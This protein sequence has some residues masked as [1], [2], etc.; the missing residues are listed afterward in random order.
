MH[1]FDMQLLVT[2]CLSKLAKTCCYFNCRSTTNEGGTCM[3]IHKRITAS[4]I[5]L[6]AVTLLA[7]CETG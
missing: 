2:V 1:R 6:L 5:T 7:G 3:S 4:F